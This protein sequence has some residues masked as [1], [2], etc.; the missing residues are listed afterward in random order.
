MS[1]RMDLLRLDYAFSVLVPVLMAIY[2]NDLSLFAHLDIVVG[3]LL[4][5]V[6]GNTLND[7]IDMRDPDETE[8]LERTKG[9][10][11]KEIFAIFAI[12]FLFGSTMFVRT[13]RENP[14]N[15]L[16][17]ALTV[18]MVV[19]YCLKKDVPIFNQI[20]LGVSH[21]FFP[22]LMIKTDAGLPQFTNEEWFLMVCFFFYAFSGQVVH[23]II[24]GDAI[25]RYPVKTQQLTVIIS[26]SITII[27]GFLTAWYLK[28]FYFIP[29]AIIP[30]GSI[31]TF[32]KPTQS[33]QGVKDVGI[34][35][36]NILLL[37]Y[38]VLIIMQMYG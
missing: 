15:L 6:A 27:M 29:I 36:G 10:H 7:V 18:G 31:Y 16:Y 14:L 24:D 21:V 11:W 25:T 22:Y 19:L 34:I 5:A 30:I 20:L 38:L 26:S 2:M 13:I 37:Y 1:R 28:D 35:L 33:T 9:Y 8:T 32:R 3:F 23:E 4:Y 12:C 17:L